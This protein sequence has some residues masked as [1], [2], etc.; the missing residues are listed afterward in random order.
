MTLLFERKITFLGFFMIITIISIG[1]INFKYHRILQNTYYQVADNQVDLGANLD[2]QTTNKENP[3]L[4]QKEQVNTGIFEQLNLVSTVAL[5]FIFVLF[6][7]FFLQLKHHFR[8]NKLHFDTLTKHNSE[9]SEKAKQQESALEAHRLLLKFTEKVPTVLFQLEMDSMGKMTFPFL[10]KGIENIVPPNL[11]NQI[12]ADGSLGFS[13]VHPDDVKGLTT[14]LQESY[15]KVDD[16]DIEYRNIFGNEIRWFK[17]AAKPEKKGSK[18]SW[19]GYLEDITERK[20]NE[21]ALQELNE[22]LSLRADELAD[23]NADLEKFAYIASHDLQEPLRVI[24]SFLELLEDENGEVISNT[25]KQYIQ[26]AKDGT[27]R[28]K[29]IIHD[30]LTYSKLGRMGYEIEE[31]NIN[32]LLSDVCM[33][34]KVLIEEKGAEIKWG[35][36]PLIK[37]GKTPI[38]QVFH[39]LIGN[40]IKYQK[41]DTQPLIKISAKELDK[42]WLFSVADNGIGIEEKH[43]DKIFVIFQRLHNRNAYSGTGIGLA[44]CKKIVENH[45]GKMW[46]DS[47]KGE[48]SVFHFTIA[49]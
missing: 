9:L 18:V 49:K 15:R 26:Y 2:K 17:G 20:K 45:K 10:S 27:D 19:Y 14:S 22:V 32:H 35:E 21:Q 7:V 5:L 16:W 28:M 25:G 38:Q 8:E 33:L 41:P 39:N 29:R 23:S 31:I 42:H 12:K 46:L 24:K 11:V 4:A 1:I 36:M 44:I 34:N 40:A 13:F 3:P 6:F 43:F 47:I 48:G 37:G 30:L